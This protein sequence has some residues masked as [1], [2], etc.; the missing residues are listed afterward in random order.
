MVATTTAY[1]VSSDEDGDDEHH[2]MSSDDDVEVEDVGSTNT[3]NIQQKKKKLVVVKKEDLIKKPMVLPRIPKSLQTFGGE[4]GSS[5]RNWLQQFEAIRVPLGWEDRQ[6]IAVCAMHLTDGAQQWYQEEG[7]SGPASQSWK[8]FKQ[9]LLTRFTPTINQLFIPEY[10]RDLAQKANEKSVDF[11]DRV[12]V[13][14]R[15]LGVDDEAW[16][17]RVFSSGLHD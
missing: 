2:T 14:L 4:S 17:V 6:S 12:R 15:D 10:T 11:L 1:D 16:M 7:V 13:E 8:W 5:V 9:A 3:N